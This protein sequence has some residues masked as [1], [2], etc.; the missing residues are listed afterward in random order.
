MYYQKSLVAC[1]FVEGYA[2]ISTTGFGANPNY[3][4]NKVISSVLQIDSTLTTKTIRNTNSGL[5]LNLNNL[6]T[7]DITVLKGS[8]NKEVAYYVILPFNAKQ[9]Y[10]LIAYESQNKYVNYTIPNCS[11]YDG[12]QYVPCTDC[13][14]SSYT[15]DNVICSCYDITQ[16]CPKQSSNV[17]QTTKI[18]FNRISDTTVDD[19]F[20]I[21]NG[22]VEHTEDNIVRQLLGSSGILI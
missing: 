11:I 18:N 14:I 15:N 8:D 12:Q 19:K 4:S 6:N 7:V 22:I 5:S 13:N 3:E 17:L 16:I 21:I 1:G 2:E 9:N 10:D 20:G